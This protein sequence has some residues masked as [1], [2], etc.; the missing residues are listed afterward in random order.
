M[1]RSKLTCP[2]KRDHFKRKVVWKDHHFWGA[3][4]VFRRVSWISQP[5]VLNKPYSCAWCC[6][7]LALV[8]HTSSNVATQ[9]NHGKDIYRFRSEPDDANPRLRNDRPC[10]ILWVERHPHLLSRCHFE[11]HIFNKFQLQRRMSQ[12]HPYPHSKKTSPKNHWSSDLW[13]SG[14][15]NLSETLEIFATPSLAADVWLRKSQQPFAAKTFPMVPLTASNGTNRQR[16][17]AGGNG[18]VQFCEPITEFAEKWLHAMSPRWWFQPI[19]KICSSNWIISP[20]RDENKKY[21]KPPPRSLLWFRKLSLI[22]HTCPPY[23]VR[24]WRKPLRFD[25]SFHLGSVSKVEAIQT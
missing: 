22:S 6:L 2:Q 24:T 13:N 19:W 20:N 18:R 25:P 8:R 3:S 5:F 23:K 4:L 10:D 17:M 9:Q 21:L 16:Q 15:L 14:F 11:N 12:N 1:N 7:D